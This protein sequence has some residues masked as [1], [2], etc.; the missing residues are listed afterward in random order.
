MSQHLTWVQFQKLRGAHAP[1][2]LSHTEKQHS[3]KQENTGVDHSSTQARVVGDA[4]QG[5][6]GLE[7]AWLKSSSKILTNEPV[8]PER[9]SAETEL[10]SLS[11]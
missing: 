4:P 1:S 5:L 6:V 7:G 10:M 2:W 9:V 11:G 3:E 8:L